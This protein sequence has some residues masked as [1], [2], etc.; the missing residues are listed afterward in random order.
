MIKVFVCYKRNPGDGDTLETAE[1]TAFQVSV[2]HGFLKL[3]EDMAAEKVTFIA[4]DTI[5]S[6]TE[7]LVKIGA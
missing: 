4:L 3:V 5:W 1:Y 7:E 6:W 2:E